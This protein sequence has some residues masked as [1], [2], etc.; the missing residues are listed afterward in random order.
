VRFAQSYI[1][2]RLRHL[3]FFS[4]AE[5]NAAI[6]A[7][8]ERINSREMRRLGMSRRQLFEAIERP[9]MQGLPPEEFEYAEW[10]LARVGIDY[11]VEVQGFFYSV[12]HAL[13]R[14]QVDTRATAHTIEIFHRGRRVAAHARRYGG[15]RHGTQPE[16]MPSAHRRYAEWTPERLQR[17]ARSIGPNTEA[18]IIAV[19][20]RRPHP[21]QGFRTCLGLLRLFRGIEAARVEAVS[22]HAVEIGAL[23][24]AS[25][26]SILKHRIDR[27][28]SPQAADGTPLLHA[29]IRGPTTIIRRLPCSP[30]PPSTCWLTSA[31]TAWPRAFATWPTIRRRSASAMPSG[32]LC[33]WNARARCVSR[34]GFKAG[35][36]PPSCVT[37]P[38]WKMST[39][40]RRAGWTGRCSSSW[41]VATGSASGVIAC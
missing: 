41:R 27:V 12:P 15:P 32:S 16:H 1:L 39:T 23:S 7:A 21:E 22:L 11:H 14:E 8:V 40:A 19:M 6:A 5:C 9:V 26:A 35:P 36:K 18:L 28:A 30:I 29:N 17:D 24:Y 13:I 2:G 4:L 37:W 34:S 38:R 25:V 33:C 20:A 3:T 10:H 31:C